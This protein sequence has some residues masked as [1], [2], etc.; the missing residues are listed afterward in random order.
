MPRR[1][2][3]PDDARI[4]SLGR[5]ARQAGALTLSLA[6]TLQLPRLDLRGVT[7]VLGDTYTRALIACRLLRFGS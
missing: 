7:T 1:P 2:D 5:R 6:L 3:R 4:G